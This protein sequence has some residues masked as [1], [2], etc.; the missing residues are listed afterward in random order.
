[1]QTIT[2]PEIRSSSKASGPTYRVREFLRDEQFILATVRP[3]LASS[4]TIVELLDGRKALIRAR[5][6]RHAAATRPVAKAFKVK[7]EEN[8]EKILQQLKAV[9]EFLDQWRVE[10]AESGLA[11][12]GEPMA[13]REE[14]VEF[15]LHY[16]I[17]S[18]EPEIPRV[19]LN[20]FL[21][22]WGHRWF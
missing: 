3:D 18:R 5:L 2:S 13:V 16:G 1:M 4:P 10:I 11:E 20:R 8:A 12:D 15:L 17:D 7:Y 22:E 6:L 21:D 9:S 14:F 19:A